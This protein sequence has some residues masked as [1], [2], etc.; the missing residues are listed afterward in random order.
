MVVV[1]NGEIV[2]ERY[3]A[4]F[5][6]QTPQL[7]W[8]LAKGITNA[9]VGIAIGQGKLSLVENALLPEWRE[10]DN[11]RAAIT[12]GN[13]LQMMSG[14]DFK[15]DYDSP[16]SDV[17]RMLFLEFDAAAFAASRDLIH[18]PGTVWRYSGADLVILN[19]VLRLRYSA[20]DI[21]YL[22][23]P[24]RELFQPLGMTTA[25]LE[26]DPSGTFM[27]S[28][29]AYASA[30]D[31]ARLGMLYLQDGVWNGRQVLPQGWVRYSTTPTVASGGVYGAHLW[32]TIPSVDSC[33]SSTLPEDAFFMLGF[34][35][36]MIAV[37]PSYRLVAV[38]LGLTRPQAAFCPV[39]F[40]RDILNAISP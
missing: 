17:R 12:V 34:D 27:G 35:G 31:W 15:E 14:L 23:M 24:N 11:A 20:G 13:L 5:D 30:R 7:G 37:V 21:D 10:P 22:D 33:S 29:F 40:M 38:R 6:Q 18:R 8:S 3:A 32:R 1:H 39:A 25:L 9:L 28:S 36:Q 16:L 2:A 19:R 26:L 4:G